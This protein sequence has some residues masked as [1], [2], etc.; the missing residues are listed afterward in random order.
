L[1]G[2]SS[3]C[4]LNPPL[5]DLSQCPCVRFL[6]HTAEYTIAAGSGRPHPDNDVSVTHCSTCGCSPSSHETEHGPTFRAQGNDA[7][8]R[9]DFSSAALLYT[10]ALHH[11]LG[12]RAAQH[13]AI[14]AIHSNRCACYLAMKQFSQALY[15]AQQAVKQAPQWAKARV[16]LGA[17]LKGLGR[18]AEALEAYAQAHRLEPDSKT[19]FQLLASAR[20]AAG[21]RVSTTVRVCAQRSMES[22]GATGLQSERSQTSP[23]IPPSAPLEHLSRSS[24]IAIA[25]AALETAMQAAQERQEA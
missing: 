2:F 15:D 11:C 16:R 7:Y 14:A 24:S 13:A 17:A 12:S 8:E 1:N 21:E 4:E 23:S 22:R 3:S 20:K 19:Y 6:K 10:K 5:R 9:S 25:A 18:E